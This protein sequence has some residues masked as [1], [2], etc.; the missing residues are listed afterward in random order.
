[1]AVAKWSD[2]VGSRE[3]AEDIYVLDQFC[4]LEGFLILKRQICWV[5]RWWV[6]PLLVLVYLEDLVGDVLDKLETFSG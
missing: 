2:S 4:S 3:E 6:R 1:M 5:G